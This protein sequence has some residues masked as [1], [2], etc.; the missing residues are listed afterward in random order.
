[1]EYL[2]IVILVM[3]QKSINLHK[4]EYKRVKNVRYKNIIYRFGE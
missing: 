1:M 4:H 3:N 2:V